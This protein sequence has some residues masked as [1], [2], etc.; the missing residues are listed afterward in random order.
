MPVPRFVRVA[1]QTVRDLLVTAGPF[2]LI[3]V[4]LLV[5][6]YWTLQPTPPKVVTLAT[7]QEQ[8]AY[9]EFGRRYAA[10]LAQHGIEVRLRTTQGAA[11]NIALLRDAGS[12]VQVAF[13]QG[14]AD[15]QPTVIGQPKEDG[16]VAL[17]SLFYEPVWLF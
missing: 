9:A 6:A 7:G 1:F 12:G 4:G 16:L 14:G 10:W 2:A 8:G 11:E 17:G 13:V 3:A 5:A 15:S